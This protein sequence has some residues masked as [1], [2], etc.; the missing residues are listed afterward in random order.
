M[1]ALGFVRFRAAGHDRGG[2]VAYRLALDHP[3]RV[4][5]LPGLDILPTYDYWQRMDRSYGLKMYHSLFPGPPH[6]FPERPIGGRPPIFGG[7]TLASWGKSNSPEAIHPR[8]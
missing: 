8:P 4:E 2:R 1:E 5:R 7:H 6:P 3:G